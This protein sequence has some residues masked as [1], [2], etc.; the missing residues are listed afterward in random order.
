MSCPSCGSEVSAGARFCPSCGHGVHARGDERRIAT[1]LFADLA[2]FTGLSEAL[3]PEHLKNVVDRCFARL[4]ADVTSHGGRVDKVVGD[5]IVALF[6]APVAHEDDAERA[7][8]TGLQMQRSITVLAEE[9]GVPL[10]LRVGVNS[11]EVLVGAMRAG[12]DYTA[13]GDA[14]NVASRLQ[15]MAAPGTVVVGPTTFAAT[16]AVV[17]YEL[18][19]PLQARGREAPVDA[20]RAIESLSTPGR[21]PR[22]V[23]APLV[24]RDDELTVLRQSVATS[25]RRSRPAV[26]FIL[27]EAGMGKSR[28]I[29]EV[30]RWAEVEHGALVLEGRCV[31]YGEANPWWP[32]AEA[33]RRACD[34]EPGDTAATTAAKVRAAVARICE[35]E[36]GSAEAGELAAGLLH[37]MGDEDALPDVDPQRARREARRSLHALIAGLSSRQPV[38][39]VLSE[40]HWADDVV[41]DLFGW[42]LD[43]LAGHPLIVLTSARFELIERWSP[44]HGRFNVLTLH[45]D[46]LDA[47]ATR[48]LAGVLGAADLPADVVDTLIH[49]SGGNPFFLEELLT[50]V[51]EGAGEE[52]PVTLRGLVAARIDALPADERS[53]LED[54]AVIGRSG[55]LAI[56]RALSGKQG[57][58]DVDAVVGRL[59]ERDLL[60]TADGRWEFR[61]DVVREVVYGTLT[62]TERAGRHWRVGSW[63]TEAGRR[64]G[65]ADEMTELVAHHYATAA[66]L[67]VEI[68]AV[69]TVPAD[70]VDVAIAAVE[71]AAAWASRRELPATAVRLLDR[72]VGLAEEGSAEWC[73]L[74]LDRALERTA[75]RDMDLARQD[76]EAARAYADRDRR[77]R[78]R[79]LT[80]E[81]VVA[82]L[83]GDLAGSAATLRRAVA[84]WREAG[85]RGGEGDALRRIGLTCLLAADRAGAEVAFNEALAIARDLGSRRDE[86]WALWHLAELSFYGGRS[87]EAESRLRDAG[88]AFREAG[89]SGGM[90]WVKGLL[91]YLKFV[92]GHRDEAEHLASGILDDL[93]DRGDRWALGMVLVLLASVR[94]WQGRAGPAAE[95]AAEARLAFVEIHDLPGELRATGVLARALAAVGRT[96]EAWAALQEVT[97]QREGVAMSAPDLGVAGVAIHLGDGATALEVMAG[98]EV[99]AFADEAVVARA[100]ALAQT[101]RIPEA[102]GTLESLRPRLEEATGVSANAWASLALVRA[103]AGEAAGAIEAADISLSTGP[104]ATYRDMAVA[105]LAKAFGRHQLGDTAAAAG[106]LERAAA[107][108]RGTDDLVTA[109]VVELATARV[110]DAAAPG[111]FP[112]AAGP[113]EYLDRLG[114]LAAGWDTAICAAV[115]GFAPAP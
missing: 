53:V 61:S 3:D 66:E 37:L 90:G 113:L 112:A 81:G 102:L 19:G 18:L 49:R 58:P 97:S 110:Q 31:P 32:I 9:M 60:A 29:E 106:E 72:G 74:L 71:R 14:V 28:L 36:D 56:L 63:L 17:R 78:A 8:R 114:A 93:R 115:K 92:Q 100:V 1:V 11:G 22:R 91:G 98:V 43:R 5:A 83:E 55:T 6:G 104:V 45:L 96:G 103:C 25:I 26:T 12:G 89:D 85:D 27:G 57:V 86:A 77:D 44:P 52:L 7:V 84:A 101:G 46:P 16:S 79:H 48:E 70:A 80:V 69:P 95:H 88:Q 94:L 68:G 34:V 20:W 105:H 33:V 54:A 76:L 30:A 99:T 4:A 40:L 51:G 50:F 59:L 73:R 35:V 107:V 67:V 108:C 23:E 87:Q 82:Q 15:T 111:P 38:V 65:R 24:G 109:A 64:T 41:L 62:K 21:R 47:G 39:L 2:G 75:L 10:Q 13:M 42:H